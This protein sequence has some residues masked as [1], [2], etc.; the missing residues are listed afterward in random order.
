LSVYKE[1]GVKRVVN[2]AFALTRLGG[3][4]LPRE[5]QEAMEEANKGYCNMWELMTRAGG[6][7]AEGTGAPAAWVTSGGFAALVMSAAACIAGKDPEKMRRLPDSTGMKNEII[8]QRNNRL[9]VYDRAMEVAG[10]RFVFVGDESWGCGVEEIEAAITDKTAAI[11]YAYPM[12]PKRGVVKLEELLRVAHNHGVPVIVDAAGMTY[13]T[14]NFR[15][16]MEMGCDLVCYG[17]K[18]VQGP[19]S[20]GFVTGRKDLV[21]AISLH[22]FIGAESGPDE[23]PGYWRSIGRGY[24]LDRQEI[25]G[26]V[27]AFRRWMRMD[28]EKERLEPAWERARYIEK[29]IRRLPG[30]KEARIT[31]FPR[32]GKGIGYNTLGLSVEFPDKSVEEVSALVNRM[33]EADPE[34]WVRYWYNS[35]EFLVNALMLQPGEEKIVVERFMEVFG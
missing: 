23:R 17:G 8:I 24:K 7:I 22:S 16:Y 10:G 35:S 4:T 1:L 15:K 9:Y 34:V 30:L 12:A 28:H 29:R 11:H 3:S 13:P 33:R 6:I 31:C 25:V 26:L 27:V 2:A 19:N 20:T 32:S 5:V 14:T 18:Y 21:E